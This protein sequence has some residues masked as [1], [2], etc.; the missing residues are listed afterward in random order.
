MADPVTW[1]AAATALSAGTA[2][3]S[4][5]QQ[6]NQ[7]EAEADLA[8]ANAKVAGQQAAAAEDA[9]RRRNRSILARQRAAIGEAGIGYGGSSEKLQQDSAVL[10]ELEALS[11]RYNGRMSALGFRTDARNARQRASNAVAGGYLSA[12]GALLGGAADTYALRTPK[13][14]PLEPITITARRIP[15]PGG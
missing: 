13:G 10:A 5:Y 4:G 9:Q 1:M 2:V 6:S 11:I 14:L 7:A 3:A 8:S 12:A 15:M